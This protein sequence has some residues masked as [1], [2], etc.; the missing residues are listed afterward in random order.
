MSPVNR[1]LAW[2]GVKQKLDAHEYNPPLITEGDLWWCAIGENVGIESAGKGRNFTRPVIVLKKFGRHGF[3]GIP[4][5]TKKSD[6]DMV[7]LLYAQGSARDRHV[8]PG[9]AF[10]L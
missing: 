7:R 8:E 6:W 10:E 4:T 5:T 9:T 3:L 1:F 2:I